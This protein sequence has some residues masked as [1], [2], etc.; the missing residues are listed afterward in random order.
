MGPPRCLGDSLTGS[1]APRQTLERLFRPRSIAVIGA[2]TR[3]DAIGLRV[4]RNLRR[5][6]FAGDIFPVNPRYREVEGLRCLPS[7][8]ALPP[9]VDCAFIAIPAE[10]GPDVLDAAGRH[11]IRT[12]F[13]NASGYAEGGAAGRALQQRLCAVAHAHGIALCGPNNMGLINVHERAA[14]WTQLHMSEI[15]AGPVAVISQSGSIALVLAQD[16]RSLGLAYIVTSGNE[17]VLSAADY[18]DY[19]AGDDRVRT[20][21]LFL[22]SIRDPARFGAAA[23]KAEAA[24]KR[25]LAMKSG[26]SPRGRALVA[27]HTDSL[28]GDDDVYDAFF[29]GH[30]IVRVRDLDEMMETAVLVTSY[31]VPPRARHFVPMTLSGGE[32]SIIA[33]VS[34]QVGLRLHPLADATVDRLRPAFP[35][36]ARPDNPLDGWGL[37]F[38]RERFGAML[39]AL[40]ADETIGAIGLAID[41]P[42]TGGADTG[43]AIAMAEHAVRVVSSGT[44]VVFFNNTAGAGPNPQVRALLTPAG[45]PYLSGMRAALSAIAH[46]LRLRDPAPDSAARIVANNSRR[47]IP[48]I[49]RGFDEQQLQDMLEEA[50][51]RMVAT[52][53]VHSPEMAAEAAAA[54]GYP[55]V[56]KG[57]AA[58]LPHKTEHNLVR[59]SL[60]SSAAVMTAYCE[61][62]TALR[63][64]SPLGEP[65]DI[66]LQPML[67]GGV[68]LI[69]GIRNDPAFGSLVIVGLGGIFVELIKSA[70]VRL[71]PVDSNEAL[72]MLAATR[73]RDLLVGFRGKGPYDIA[74]AAAAIAAL[75]RI[76]VATRD[77]IESVEINPLI[78]LERG[79]LGVD[80]LVRRSEPRQQAS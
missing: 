16:E 34:A 4:I 25:L 51:V 42:A 7:I 5:M 30:G 72:D 1:N 37:G 73:A 28:A 40:A 70:A 56:L 55:V 44:R 66:I 6:G 31:P 38:S 18:L 19:I 69:V 9:D 24:G 68:E 13:V 8:E 21:V 17:A 50:G 79:A 33:D 74:A 63:E 23:L 2:S 36:S 64:L 60:G 35:P 41:A 27:A 76:G 78:V 61:I 75:S 20:V 54:L 22:E 58:H 48:R 39:D 59:L 45:I 11:G 77:V 67:S 3:A 47:S 12:A 62:A 52:H 26:A 53:I 43:Y 49:A 80:L 57:R 10:Q 46:W 14:I 32:A 15:S 29:V 65:G 71:G